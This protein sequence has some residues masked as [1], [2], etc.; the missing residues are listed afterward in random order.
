MVLDG[1]NEETEEWPEECVA[2]QQYQLSLC[3]GPVVL[4]LCKTGGS[5]PHLFESKFQGFFV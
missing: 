2:T 4:L 1:E 5:L 3:F